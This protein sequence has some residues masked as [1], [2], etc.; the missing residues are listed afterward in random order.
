MKISIATA[1][2][3]F[4]S[5]AVVAVEVSSTKKKSTNLRRRR[6]QLVFY[7]PDWTNHVCEQK[8][9]SIFEKWELDEMY[10]TLDECC[11]DKFWWKKNKCMQNAPEGGGPDP[12]PP[13][14]D[15]PDEPEPTDGTTGGITYL[16]DWEDKKCHSKRTGALKNFEIKYSRASIRNCCDSFFYWEEG[17]CCSRSGGCNAP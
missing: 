9:M 15:E 14:P 7:N 12:D 10:D 2:L 6:T 17:G 8:T 16:P 3:C 11:T 13:E 1:A 5:C 4:R